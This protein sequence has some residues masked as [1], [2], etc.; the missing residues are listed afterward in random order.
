MIAWIPLIPV[1]LGT[2]RA[3][4]VQPAKVSYDGYKVFR[5][6]VGDEVDKVKNLVSN[7]GLST[8]K[9]APRANA[10]ADI[11]VPPHQLDAFNSEVENMQLITM[12]EDLGASISEEA[13]FGVYAGTY[14]SRGGGTLLP[15]L[16]T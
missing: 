16:S 12:H 9:G 6:S 15:V 2:A 5:V 11:V 4:A 1:L 8:W 7:L 14:A 13:K 3:A 10:M